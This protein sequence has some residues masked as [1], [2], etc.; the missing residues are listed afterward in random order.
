MRAGRALS[1]GTG[2]RSASLPSEQVAGRSDPV[3]PWLGTR[4]RR[5]RYR[6]EAADGLAAGLPE[7]WVPPL[8]CRARLQQRLTSGKSGLE[9]KTRAL[10]ARSGAGN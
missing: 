2:R 5:A 3:L 7:P 6:Q 9:G 8:L 4:W 10:G 1:A